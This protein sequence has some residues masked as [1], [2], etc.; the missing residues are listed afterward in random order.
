[1]ERKAPNWL[2]KLHRH[3]DELRHLGECVRSWSDKPLNK[4]R[5]WLKRFSGMQEDEQEKLEGSGKLENKRE[6]GRLVLPQHGESCKESIWRR[7]DW[8]GLQDSGV[9]DRSVTI[10][11]CFWR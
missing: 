9:R 4:S 1:M 3:D 10:G 6:M 5:G 11:R 7:Y 8:Y 2:V